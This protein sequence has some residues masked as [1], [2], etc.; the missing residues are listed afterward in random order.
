MNRMDR[1][2]GGKNSAPQGRGGLGILQF[3]S[4]LVILSQRNA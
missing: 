2:I 1:I 4:I 3:L